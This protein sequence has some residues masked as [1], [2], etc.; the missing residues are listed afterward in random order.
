MARYAAGS[1]TELNLMA[2]IDH[3]IP[4][5]IGRTSRE[6][7]AD[8][9]IIGWPSA[10]S[11]LDKIVGEK[12]ES[13]LNKT[14][15]NLFMCRLDNPLL[16]HRSVTL[17][18]PPLAESELGFGFWMEKMLKL[19]R[20]LSLPL[21]FVA[22]GRTQAAAEALLQKLKSSVQVS[23][24]NYEDWDNVHGLEAFAKADALLVF[25]SSRYGELSYRD[26]LDGLAKKTGRHF[27]NRNL[28]LIFPARR[29]NQHIHDYE[30]VHA[31]PILK[32]IGREIGNMLKRH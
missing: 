11:F 7:F 22:N 1:E 26:S 19:A 14:D 15:A 29:E 27:K 3:N 20:E 24:R 8:C 23:H 2:T 25:V 28:I 4:S 9:I 10:T 5:G 30:D 18:V 6:V 12:S 17:F 16:D 21:T 13:I 31:V 32:K